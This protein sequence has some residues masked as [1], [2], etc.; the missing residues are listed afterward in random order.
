MPRSFEISP[1]IVQVGTG[2]NNV[3]IAFGYDPT[4]HSICKMIVTPT[5][6]LG[7]ATEVTF[8]RGGRNATQLGAVVTA[9]QAAINQQAAQGGPADSNIVPRG[10]IVQF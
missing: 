4:D 7:G 8:N 9:D 3:S 2:T 5:G 6:T 1:Q 10:T